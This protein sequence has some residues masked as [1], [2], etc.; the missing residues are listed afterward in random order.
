MLER[1]IKIRINNKQLQQQ[2]QLRRQTTEQENP[3]GLLLK[4]S[5]SY[6]D[7]V[8]TLKWPYDMLTMAIPG[9]GNSV[10][11]ACSRYGLNLP[12]VYSHGLLGHRLRNSL[13][14]DVQLPCKEHPSLVELRP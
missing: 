2:Q 9:A 3:L 7:V 1:F 6:D 5:R 8:W 10:V 11:F 13:I 14:L 4:S 12:S